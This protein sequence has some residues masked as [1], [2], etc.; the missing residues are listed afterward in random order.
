MAGVA[1]LIGRFTLPEHPTLVPWLSSRVF[2]LSFHIFKDFTSLCDW[3]LNMDWC[4]FLMITRHVKC[5]LNIYHYR[6]QPVIPILIIQTKHH[7]TSLAGT[8]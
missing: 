3:D 2:Y 5:R 8:F 4:L 7:I 6:Q 1:S